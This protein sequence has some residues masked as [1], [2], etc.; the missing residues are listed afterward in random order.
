MLSVAKRAFKFN[1][2][3]LFKDM[4]KEID[5]VSSDHNDEMVENLSN[6]LKRQKN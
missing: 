1:L 2:E 4:L 3:S 5:E 6:L